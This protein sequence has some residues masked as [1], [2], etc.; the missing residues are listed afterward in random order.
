MFWQFGGRNG[1]SRAVQGK[2]KFLKKK[3]HK[4]LYDLSNDIEEKNKLSK[5]Y[6]EIF[7]KLEKIS[8]D[9]YKEPRSQKDDGKYTG[10]PSKPKKK[11]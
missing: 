9:A 3:D 10:R 1:D 6:S 5:K 4:A 8:V 11:K 7:A 2:W